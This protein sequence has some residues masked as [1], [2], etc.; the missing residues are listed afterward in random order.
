MGGKAIT[1][2]WLSVSYIHALY[3]YL[4]NILSNLSHF[5][6]K[7]ECACVATTCFSVMAEYL[8]ICRLA[9]LYLSCA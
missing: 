9:S 1:K 5:K 7:V 8:F 4:I 2:T 6:A 3:N